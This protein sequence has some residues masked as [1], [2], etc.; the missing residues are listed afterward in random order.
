M[1][2]FIIIQENLE[3]KDVLMIATSFTEAYGTEIMKTI[4]VFN[5]NTEKAEAELVKQTPDID[6]YVLMTD[7]YYERFGVTSSLYTAF[8]N[9]NSDDTLRIC[10]PSESISTEGTFELDCD[11]LTAITPDKIEDYES[12]LEEALRRS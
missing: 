1:T 3:Y 8:E 4:I 9:V 5:N 6:K 12:V 11:K 7:Y 10:I 2:K